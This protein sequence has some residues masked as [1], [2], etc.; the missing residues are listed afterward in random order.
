MVV[1]SSS[2]DVCTSCKMFFRLVNYGLY[3]IM[4]RAAVVT[5]L[6]AWCLQQNCTVNTA[7]SGIGT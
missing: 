5:S 2:V 7:D 1:R 6:A 4:V 3:H